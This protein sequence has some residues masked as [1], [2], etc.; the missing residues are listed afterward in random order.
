MSEL[1]AA[2][3]DKHGKEF[4]LIGP[5]QKHPAVEWRIYIALPSNASGFDSRLMAREMS[6]WRCTLAG[7]WAMWAEHNRVH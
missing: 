4:S 7:L 5:T 3:P 6:V 2:F 1:G